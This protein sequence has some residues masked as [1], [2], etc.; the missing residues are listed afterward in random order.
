MENKTFASSSSSASNLAACQDKA[1]HAWSTN[2][3]SSTM[4]N[5]QITIINDMK[6]Q[7]N[8]T[9]LRKKVN[10]N[11]LQDDPILEFADKNYK[12]PL[13][14]K[15]LKEKIVMLNEQMEYCNREIKIYKNKQS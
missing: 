13:K 4:S 12:A 3:I 5:I 8:V 7:E 6:K 15:N 9:R 11:K 1:Q 2:N 14:F 10:R